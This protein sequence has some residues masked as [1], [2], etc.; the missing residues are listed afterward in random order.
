VKKIFTIS[1]LVVYL[2]LSVGMNI[3]V[4][5]CGGESQASLVTTSAKDPCVCD[6]GASSDEQSTIAPVDMCCT[7]EFKAVQLDD[8]Q[9]VVP[10]HVEQNLSVAGI[11]PSIEHSI[12]NVQYSTSNIYLDT[13][14]PPD[15]DY[16]TSNSVFLI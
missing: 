12:F 13:S 7:M 2:T 15:K 1:F 8:V 4:H 3:L 6:D 16:Q 9:T 11:L 5:T 10:V 14:P